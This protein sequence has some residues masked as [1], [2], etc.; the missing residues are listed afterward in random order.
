MTKRYYFTMAPEAYDY[1]CTET[2][3]AE[4]PDGL[5]GALYRLVCVT[6]DGNDSF[7]DNQCD[8]YWS[9]LHRPWEADSQDAQNLGF[10]SLAD[11]GVC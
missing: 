8:R 1:G 11:L 9:G 4:V 7:A 2:V 10:P 5:S 3:K 6:H